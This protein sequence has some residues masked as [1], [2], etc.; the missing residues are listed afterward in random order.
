MAKILIVDDYPTNREFLVSLLSHLHHQLLEAADGEEALAVSQAERPELVITDL[1]MPRMDGYEFAHMLRSDPALRATRIIF[2]SAKY[3]KWET[4]TLDKASQWVRHLEKPSRPEEIL[5]AVDEALGSAVP[6]APVATPQQFDRAHLRLLTDKLARKVHMLDALNRLGQKLA[7]ESDPMRLLETLCGQARE[8]L[9]AQ[10]TVVAISEDGQTLRHFF[11]A[12]AEPELAERVGTPPLELALLRH[13]VAQEHSLRWNAL[14]AE[15]ASAFPA[16]YPAARNLLW[17]PIDSPSRHYGAFYVTNKLEGAEF[18]GDDE[19]VASTLGLQLGVAYE[20]AQRFEL[21]VREA[22]ERKEAQESL[23]RLKDELELRVE[24]RTAELT[25]ANRELEN[26][27]WIVAHDLKA[28]LRGVAALAE[29]LQTDYADKLGDKGRQW[30]AQ[31]NQRAG[32]MNRM[33]EE[34]L[35]YS[36]LGR[37]REEPQLVALAELVPLLVQDLAPPPHVHIRIASGLPV[38]Q[39][40]P[41]RLRELFQNLI[42]N[43]IKYGDKPEVEIRVAWADSGSVWQFSVSDNGPGIE[44]KHFERIFKMFQTLAPK[45]KTDSTG[46]GLALVKRIVERAGGRVWVDSRLSQGSTFHFTWPKPAWA[47]SSEPVKRMAA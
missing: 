12:G 33:V 41:V 6:P 3:Q 45:D 20:N 30:L 8:I 9:Q 10:E 14:P 44:E 39:G 28:P 5:Q 46:V 11:L 36:R 32:R 22:A 42:S 26:F 4:E 47:K 1:V 16:G 27:A 23:R 29:W 34:I 7:L 38:V 24:R 15:A 40:E 25:A 35:Q 2:Y 43:A 37:T 21:M 19:M 17:A 31:M 13:L 18:S